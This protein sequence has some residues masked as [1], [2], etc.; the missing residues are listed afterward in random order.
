MHSL[1]L[2]PCG[3]HLSRGLPPSVLSSFPLHPSP[4]HTIIIVRCKVMDMGTWEGVLCVCFSFH[5]DAGMEIRRDDPKSLKVLL[6]SLYQSPSHYFIDALLTQCLCVFRKLS[7]RFNPRLLTQ[8]SLKRTGIFHNLAKPATNS[9]IQGGIYLAFILH[10][11][12]S[13]QVYAGDYFCSQ[14]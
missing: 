9:L 11:Q 14:D 1:W 13:C 3:V 8:L 4:H 12:V 6:I 2:G 7:F 5:T 10:L